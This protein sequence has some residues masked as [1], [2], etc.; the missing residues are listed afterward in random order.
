MEAVAA[1]ARVVELPG[2]AKLCATGGF[3]RWNAVSKQATCGR[4]G[5]RCEQRADR[6]EVVRLVQRRERDELLQPGRATRGVDPDRLGVLGAA[7]DDA[8]TDGGEPVVVPV[9]RLRAQSMMCAIAP[10]WPSCAVLPAASRTADLPR[11]VLRD[12]ARR[13]VDR[14][15]PGP[16]SELELGRPARRTART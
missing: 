14:P 16:G 7:V 12:E 2:S 4:S 3:E 8:V 1:H 15:R 6:R 5:A 13:R 11:R 9:R 10:S